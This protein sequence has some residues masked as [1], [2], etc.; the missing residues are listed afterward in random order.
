MLDKN[1]MEMTYEKKT[2]WMYMGSDQEQSYPQFGE[3]RA[4]R[5][6]SYAYLDCG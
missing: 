5:V 3:H 6:S 1:A 4:Y 2:V